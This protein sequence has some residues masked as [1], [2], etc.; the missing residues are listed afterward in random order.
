MAPGES[1]DHHRQRER[2]GGSTDGVAVIFRLKKVL[3]EFRES[4]VKHGAER[5]GNYRQNVRYFYLSGSTWE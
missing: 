2:P 1:E 4:S 3:E 5:A